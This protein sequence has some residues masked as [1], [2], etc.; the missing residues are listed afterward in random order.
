MSIDCEDDVCVVKFYFAVSLMNDTE[1]ISLSKTSIEEYL[2][3]VLLKKIFS[4]TQIHSKT[5][6]IGS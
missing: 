3:F 5:S 1:R 6:E 4:E 2:L